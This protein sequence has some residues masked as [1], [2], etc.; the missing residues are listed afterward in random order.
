[1]AK[2]VEGVGPQ[3]GSTGS[4]VPTR[5]VVSGILV[6]LTLCFIF[7]NTASGRLRFLSWSFEA[8]AWAWIALI[9]ASGLAV[10]SIFPW[11]RRRQ[12]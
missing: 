4:A 2:L 10:G 1:M 3:G 6:V 12:P 7:Q 8:P 5:L 11:F 9:F